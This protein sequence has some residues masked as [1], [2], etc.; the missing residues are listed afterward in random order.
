[1]EQANVRRRPLHGHPRSSPRLWRCS[2][3]PPRH[4]DRVDR[5]RARRRPPPKA[6]QGPAAMK[7]A[8]DSSG[9]RVLVAANG[10]T[11]YSFDPD[12]KGG[13][14]VCYGQC[15]AGVAAPRPWPASRASAPGLDQSLVGT[16]TRSDGTEA[17]HLRRMAALL[18]RVRQEGRPD[19]R[20][21]RRAGVVAG[22]AGR[23]PD[24]APGDDP[25]RHE[26]QV[27]DRQ[28]RL[29]ALPVHARQGGREVDMHRRASARRSGPP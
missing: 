24:P 13:K 11:L 26:R 16:V 14:S 2:P 10:R 4:A 9:Q 1:M 17:G 18:L 22:D 12:T 20:A 28:P 15:A 3:W 25:D 29:H 23:K 6:A 27:R 21:G 7:L 5:R 8:T 19:E